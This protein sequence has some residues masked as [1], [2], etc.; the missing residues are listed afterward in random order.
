[1]KIIIKDGEVKTFSDNGS[2]TEQLKNLESLV[3]ATQ[4]HA[5]NMQKVAARTLGIDPALE[6][7]NDT[8]RR[9]LRCAENTIATADRQLCRQKGGHS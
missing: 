2:I 8:L 1:M 4:K 9:Q 7:A 6:Q 3:I 5:A